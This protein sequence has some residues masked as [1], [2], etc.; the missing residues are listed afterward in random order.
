MGSSST[1]ELAMPASGRR[2]RNSPEPLNETAAHD[3]RD[4]DDDRTGQD[5]LSG[6]A[7]LKPRLVL[8]L[9]GKSM[10]L[11]YLHI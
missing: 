7:W 9:Q 8:I 5:R 10:L 6:L 1:Q 4:Q 3:E 2:S 11:T